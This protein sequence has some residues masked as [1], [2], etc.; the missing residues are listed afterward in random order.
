MLRSAGMQKPERRF[1]ELGEREA[2]AVVKSAVAVGVF[3]GLLLWSLLGA[4]LLL[5]LRLAI[6]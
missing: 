1:I 3:Q 4:L 5:V 6:G 2:R